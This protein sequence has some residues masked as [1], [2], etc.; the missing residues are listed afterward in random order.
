MAHA[1]PPRR[2]GNEA[3]NLRA[4]ARLIAMAGLILLA[5]GFPTTLILAA[6]SLSPDGISPLFALLAG[7][8]PIALGWAACHYAS[9]RLERAKERE[10]L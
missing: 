5:I 3:Q 8:P 2:A 6:L 4:E 10:R 9:T 7:G 1:S